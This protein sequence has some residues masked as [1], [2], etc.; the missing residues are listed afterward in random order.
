MLGSLG[1]I[2]G[3]WADKFDQLAGV[4]EL[5]HHADDLPVGRVLLGALAAAVLAGVS[6]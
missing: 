5:R 1:L 3:M 2:A 4:P 6:T